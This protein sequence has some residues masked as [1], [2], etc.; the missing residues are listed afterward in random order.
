LQ[1]GRDDGVGFAKDVPAFRMTDQHV[2]RAEVDEHLRRDRPGESTRFLRGQI[3]RT[4]AQRRSGSDR[5]DIAQMHE[6]GQHAN[7]DRA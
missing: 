2:R 5:N 1:L 6:R 4:D 7:L 3:L